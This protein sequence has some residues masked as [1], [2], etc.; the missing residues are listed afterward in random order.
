MRMYTRH[1]SV[2]QDSHRAPGGLI[3]SLV[4]T[5]RQ[6]VACMKF[7]RREEKRLT[8]LGKSALG[9]IVTN[10]ISYTVPLA[11]CRLENRT[12]NFMTRIIVCP[13]SECLS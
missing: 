11:T 5:Q 10:P 6:R 13:M 1:A 9:A 4:M 8:R 12:T 7:S 3:D 2:N